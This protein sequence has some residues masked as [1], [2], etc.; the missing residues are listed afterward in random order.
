M[1]IISNLS[2]KYQI[3]AS[4]LFGAGLRINE[5]LRLRIKDI[6]FHNKSIFVF[7]GKGNKDRYTL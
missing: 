7:R 3:I 5:A 4:L 1:L 6:D 2:G